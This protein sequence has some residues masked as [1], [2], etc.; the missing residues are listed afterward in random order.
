MEDEECK[1]AAQSSSSAPAASASTP[2]KQVSSA[3]ATPS[4]TPANDSSSSKT[5]SA[6]AVKTGKLVKAGALWEK[7]VEEQQSEN[8]TKLHVVEVLLEVDLE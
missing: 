7:Q 3:G 5:E 2:V 6:K 1:T 8:R 4:N